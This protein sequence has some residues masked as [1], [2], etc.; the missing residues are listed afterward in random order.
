MTRPLTNPFEVKLVGTTFRDPENLD[1]LERA[2][3]ETYMR[4][5]DRPGAELVREPDNTH[6]A[7]ALAVVCADA[8]GMI[9][10]L[11]AAIAERLSPQIDGGE[12]WACEVQEVLIHPEYPNR[13][14][15]VVYVSRSG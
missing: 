7:F 12:V 14:G 5:A 15:V 2:M 3:A 9:G 4:G 8:G 6:D 10:Y 1:R 13:P 11:P